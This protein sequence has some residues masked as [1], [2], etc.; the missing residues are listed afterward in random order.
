MSRRQLIVLGMIVAIPIW[1]IIAGPLGPVAF[2]KQAPDDSTRTE[3][4]ET[5]HD[6]E[7]LFWVVTVLFG[8][9]MVFLIAGMLVDAADSA[10]ESARTRP[11]PG[12]D[13]GEEWE[14]ITYET[15][16]LVRRPQPPK[17]DPKSK[18]QP[19]PLP[20]RFRL[21]VLSVLTVLAFTLCL[22]TLY[23][24]HPGGY[25]PWQRSGQSV[26]ETQQDLKDRWLRLEAMLKEDEAKHKE[27]IEATR[28]QL[29]KADERQWEE[30]L[31]RIKQEF[32]TQ[33]APAK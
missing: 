19:E 25:W 28:K 10:S 5:K 17:P 23:W 7:I 11:M 12:Y 21:G 29:Q 24:E 18:L 16:R 27:R 8:V 13:P 20:L 32:K 1:G 6:A 4:A 22:A 9:F 33:Q 31:N 26:Q 3:W 30:T 15:A 14:S 2:D